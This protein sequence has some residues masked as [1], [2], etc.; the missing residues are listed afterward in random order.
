MDVEWIAKRSQGPATE[1]ANALARSLDETLQAVRNLAL[2]LRPPILDDLGIGSALQEL[3]GEMTRRSG[4]SIECTI[5]P[6]AASLD[7]NTAVAVYRIAQE[8]L[9]NAVRHSECHNIE[10]SLDRPNGKVELRVEDD[11]RG[12]AEATLAQAST[13]AGRSLGLLGM[14]ERAGLLGGDVQVLPR[15]PSGTVI[16]ATIPQPETQAEDR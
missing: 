14:R 4:I 6:A 11:G 1:A 10:V 13:G 12:I 2:G 3:S 5:D 7:R 9:S 16:L 8:A 15:T